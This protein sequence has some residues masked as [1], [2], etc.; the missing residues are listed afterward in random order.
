MVQNL[1]FLLL[2]SKVLLTRRA[3]N[4][5]SVLLHS[6]TAAA[7][8][9]LKGTNAFQIENISKNVI[10]CKLSLTF[11]HQNTLNI[12]QNLFW[13]INQ[14]IC[15][16]LIILH[17]CITE[18][19]GLFHCFNCTPKHSRSWKGFTTASVFCFQ[20]SCLLKLANQAHFFFPSLSHTSMSVGSPPEEHSAGDEHMCECEN[21]LFVIC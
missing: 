11:C 5:T 2:P 21:L 14:N 9:L 6:I 1:C 18:R 15:I 3:I 4:S 19:S 13:R 20:R 7:R 16:F 17:T 10:D 8:G 12:P